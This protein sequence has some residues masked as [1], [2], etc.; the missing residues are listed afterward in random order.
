MSS[1]PGKVTW[2]PGTVLHPL[3][4]VLVGCGRVGS[5]A[6]LITVAWTGIVC[7]EPPMLSI[8][9]RPGR[10]SHALIRRDQV[11]SVNIPAA[12]QAAAVDWCGV[13]SGRD[14]D[15]FA[16][17]GLTPLP[18]PETGAPLV[19]EC[20]VCL[21]CRV[22]NRRSLGSH[23]LFLANI[24]AVYADE[25]LVDTRT[26]SFSLA[27]SL[28]LCYAHGSYYELGRYLGFFG[29]SVQK[30]KPHTRAPA[31]PTPPPPRRSPRRRIK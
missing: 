2:K 20:P 14:V 10:H 28:P 26:N 4:V 18:G 13:K 23:D 24:V 29:F 3:P 1:L 12:T 5:D 7:S 30:R 31:R 6:N 15:K 21:E 16:A 17:T 8:S 9:V 11:F 27:R 22:V 25:A 19:A